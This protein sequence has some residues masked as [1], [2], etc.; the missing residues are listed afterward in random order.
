MLVT[1]ACSSKV[2]ITEADIKSDIFYADKGTRPFTGKCRIV[3]SDTC[4]IKEEFTYKQGI[5]HGKAT[6]WYKNG[7]IRRRGSY[8]YGQISGRW[9]FW[10]ENGKKTVEANYK[11]DALDGSYIIYANGRIREKGQFTDNRRTG[12]WFYYDEKGRR[13]PEQSE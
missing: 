2:T 10:D 13:I 7:Q 8:S 6:A 1:V 9:E 11:N 12:K 4:L 5:L 3:F